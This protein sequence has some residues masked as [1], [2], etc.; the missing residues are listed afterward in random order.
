M[1]C[2]RLDWALAKLGHS[3]LLA[4]RTTMPSRHAHVL[5]SFEFIMNIM[6]RPGRGSAWAHS[7]VVVHKFGESGRGHHVVDCCHLFEN[8][9]TKYKSSFDILSRPNVAF[10]KTFLPFAA[11]RVLI[12]QKYIEKR[13]GQ[14][15]QRVKPTLW[16][17]A[18][19]FVHPLRWKH[20][21]TSASVKGIVRPADRSLVDPAHGANAV[22]SCLAF[23]V[24]PQRIFLQAC[25]AVG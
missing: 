21:N 24:A 3:I 12:L 15:L 7:T 10:Q 14:F 18:L 4:C 19:Y 1:P 2:T 20:F 9:S 22:V 23:F 6:I 8:Y 11:E 17:P 25:T 16:H 13:C 5:G